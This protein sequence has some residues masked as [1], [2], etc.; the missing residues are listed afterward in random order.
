M[1]AGGKNVAPAV[2]EDRVR[3][4]PLVSQCV[5]VGD[6]QPFIAALV[7]V[8][9]EA[10]PT[11]LAAHGLPADTTVDRLRDDDGAAGR[12][13]GRDRHG[14]P[15]RLQGRGDQGVPDPARATSPRRPAS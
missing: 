9:E 14:Q 1:T 5:V 12:D 7:T 10:L 8:D 2:L 15:G 3:A 11:W 4:H 6:R 13:P